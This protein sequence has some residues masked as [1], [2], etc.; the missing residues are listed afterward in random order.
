MQEG[1]DLVDPQTRQFSDFP[2]FI[3]QHLSKLANKRVLMYCTGA[4]SV[5][6][7][8]LSEVLH[9]CVHLSDVLHERVLG[10]SFKQGC[11]MQ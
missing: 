4:C 6:L 1:V 7:S 11:S 5:A 10:A 8:S 3:D 9:G 2:A